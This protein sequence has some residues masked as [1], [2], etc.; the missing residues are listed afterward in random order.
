MN[1]PDLDL[2]ALRRAYTPEEAPPC[3][4]CGAKLEVARMGGGEATKWACS[5]ADPIRTGDWDHYSQSEWRQYRMGD[6]RVL[7]LIDAYEAVRE[8]V[9]S[10]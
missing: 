6:S 10:A 4:V 7:A 2:D 8:A 1:E 9:K 5:V 3:R